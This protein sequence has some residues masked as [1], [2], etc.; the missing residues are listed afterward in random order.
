MHDTATILARIMGPLLLLFGLIHVIA[1]KNR[2]KIVDDH[3]KM[4]GMMFLFGAFNLILG[5]VIVNL[6][7]VWNWNIFLSLTLLGWALI[8][9]GIACW[10]IP[11]K[12]LASRRSGTSYSILLKFI[13]PIWGVILIWAGYRG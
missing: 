8:L 6:Y 2:K 10:Y 13:V 1:P 9:R 5:L 4:P 7:N 11:D 3:V 12:F